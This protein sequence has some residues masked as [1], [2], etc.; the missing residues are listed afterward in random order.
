MK[1]VYGKVLSINPKNWR[2]KAKVDQGG[3]RRAEAKRVGKGSVRPGG[4]LARQRGRGQD[5][6]RF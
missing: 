1:R 4:A 2:K 6:E 5:L 3:V